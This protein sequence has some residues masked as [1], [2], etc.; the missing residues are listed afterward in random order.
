VVSPTILV[1]GALLR[2][3]PDAATSAAPPPSETDLLRLARLSQRRSLDNITAYFSY[4]ADGAARS[5][6]FVP[7][8]DSTGVAWSER[9]VVTPRIDD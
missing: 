3:T 7:G 6:M 4:V 2:P 9:I 5:L 8:S 1:V